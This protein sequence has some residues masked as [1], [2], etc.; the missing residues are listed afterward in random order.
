MTNTVELALAMGRGTVGKT[1]RPEKK[2]GTTSMKQFC[3]ALFVK[4]FLNPE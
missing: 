3:N 4:R 2:G 1:G